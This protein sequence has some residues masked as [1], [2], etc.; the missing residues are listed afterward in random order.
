RRARHPFP[1]RR[2]SDLGSK[3]IRLAPGREGDIWI[4]LFWG[5]LTRSTDSGASFSAISGVSYAGAVG[6]GKAAPDSDYPTVFIWG[7]VND[8]DRKSTRLNSSH[9]KI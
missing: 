9:V 6:F 5:G 4:P 2:S 8:V 7:T 3:L 1:T